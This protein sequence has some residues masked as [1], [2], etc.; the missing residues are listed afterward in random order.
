MQLKLDKDKIGFDCDDV[1]FAFNP[2]FLAHTNALHKTSFTLEDITHVPYSQCPKLRQLG[3]LAY[4]VDAVKT[5][6]TTPTF[7]GL[8][9]VEG[10]RE[11]IQKLKQEGYTLYAITGRDSALE[12]ITQTALDH[13]YPGAF[14]DLV[15]TNHFGNK[16]IKKSEVGIRLQISILV[17]DWYVHARDCATEGITVVLPHYP[18]N[19]EGRDS[20]SQENPFI[21]NYIVTVEK[22]NMITYLIPHL[23]R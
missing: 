12:G 11:A 2:A 3:D 6:T 1:L 23:H 22:P 8:P 13:H 19:R 18:C 17:D 9:P 15:C 7:A 5:F 10:M 21:R 4:W 20:L 16:K 14:S